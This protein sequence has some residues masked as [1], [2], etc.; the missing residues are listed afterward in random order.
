VAQNSAPDEI[1]IDIDALDTVTLRCLER[2]VKSVLTKERKMSANSAITRQYQAELTATG[3][4]EKI[5]N[6]ERQLNELN[7]SLGAR[8]RKGG[9]KK[10]EPGEEDV[11][12]D[13]NAP[14]E[15]YPSV[16]IEKDAGDDS[17]SESD[18]SESDSESSSSSSDSDSS[19]TSSAS[20]DSESKTGNNRKPVASKESNAEITTTPPTQSLPPHS[21]TDVP[22]TS[23]QHPATSPPV[24]STS[25]TSPPA[26]PSHDRVLFPLE[27]PVHTPPT[28][29]ENNEPAP[30]IK[31]STGT[32]KAPELPSTVMASWSTALMQDNPSTTSDPAPSDPMWSQFQNKNIM[33]KQKEKEREEQEELLRREREEREEEK[34]RDEER[35]RREA[36][37][38]ELKRQRDTEAENEQKRAAVMA[39]RAAARA[40]RE[41]L[42][43]KNMTEQSNLM[44]SFESE[45][46]PT[47]L[48]DLHLKPVD[49][50]SDVPAPEEGEL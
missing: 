50:N 44:A 19:D 48:L 46:R 31:Q 41:M 4:Q 37:E 47:P 9:K 10:G 2:Y 36:E 32:K 45:S 42:V 34:K 6:V 1:E 18:S 21:N 7:R 22:A 30:E 39:Q 24:S 35:K 15:N 27:K 23:E 16:H 33:Q 5:K 14:T 12:I 26:Q 40:A 8:G 11:V 25:P 17:G 13:D 49:V 28:G 43:G 3:T 29:I 20:S 38:A